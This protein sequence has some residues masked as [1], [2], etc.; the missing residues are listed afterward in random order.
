LAAFPEYKSYTE[1]GVPTTIKATRGS[2]RIRH[3]ITHYVVKQ[4]FKNNALI[5]ATI[6]TGRTHQIRVHFT[7]IGHSIVGDP[8]YGKKSKFIKRQALHAYSLS[9]TFDGKEHTF[10]RELPDDFKELLAALNTL[11][12]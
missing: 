9:F 5:E 11:N 4:Y 10:C 7:A 1:S 12:I 2:R 6:V 3:A 8:V